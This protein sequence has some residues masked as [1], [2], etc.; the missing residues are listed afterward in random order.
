[1]MRLARAFTIAVPLA[2][3]GAAPGWALSAC[4]SGYRYQSAQ[5]NC[6]S[7][8]APGCPSTFYPNG[9]RTLCINDVTQRTQGPTCPSGY[10]FRVDGNRGQCHGERPASCPSG[11]RV[12]T[13]SGQCVATRR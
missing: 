6:Q 3:L 11:Q 2:A 13:R 7:I 9:T 5:G 8:V 10:R 12:D 1:M 4:P